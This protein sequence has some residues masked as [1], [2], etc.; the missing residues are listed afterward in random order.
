L[1]PI[2]TPGISDQSSKVRKVNNFEHLRSEPTNGVATQQLLAMVMPFNAPSRRAKELPMLKKVGIVMFIA[3]ITVLHG[4]LLGQVAT[5]I[6]AGIM[7]V[8]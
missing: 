4:L 8:D 3:L 1:R 6:M 2:L 5:V 7:L